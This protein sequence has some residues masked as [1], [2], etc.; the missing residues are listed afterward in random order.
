MYKCD[1]I[2]V[3][4]TV[5]S[6]SAHRWWGMFLARALRAPQRVKLYQYAICPFCN[7]TKAALDL[8]RVPYEQ[9]EVRRGG[10]AKSTVYR[11]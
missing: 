10:A 8:L 7:K 5:G 4:P 1:P 9:V 2:V 6:G 11:P 3:S